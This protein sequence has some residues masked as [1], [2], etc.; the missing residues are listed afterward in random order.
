[1]KKELQIEMYTRMVMIRYFE[2]EAVKQLRSGMPGFIH[3]YVGEEAMAVGACSAIR[4][5][6]YITS[7]HRGHGHIIAKGA[8][9][10]KM[11][12]E[13]W[14]KITGY[15]K[16]KGGSMH[17]ASYDLGILGANGIVGGGIPIATGAGLSIKI[18]GSDKVVVCFMGD[19]ATNQGTFH[20]SVNIAAAN[21]L[22]VIYVCENNLYGVGTYQPSVRAIEDIAD[23]APAY[24]IPGK[25]VDGNDVEDVYKA[26]KSASKRAR[27]GEGPT[28]IEGKT[29]RWYGHFEGDKDGRPKDEIKKWKA[30]DPVARYR[31]KLLSDG[32]LNQSK[33]KE[34]IQSVE[35]EVADAV[36]FAHD[37]KLPDI[38]E[39]MTDIYSN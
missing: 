11:M 14:G 27:R 13:L 18:D 38:S 21:K 3:S 37:S 30:K 17:I 5:D 1:M 39:A 28:L 35:K 36:R 10:S 8:E 4:K 7:T 25:I 15:N 24:G 2:E 33:D 12:A 6:D 34:I 32:V 31:K 9:L 29:Y 23:R 19:G 16:G 20:E 26:V 22:P